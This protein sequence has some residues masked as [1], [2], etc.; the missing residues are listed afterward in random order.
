MKKQIISVLIVILFVGLFVFLF[1]RPDM[2][3]DLGEFRD[4]LFASVKNAESLRDTLNDKTAKIAEGGLD[5][6]G[7]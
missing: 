6:A 2:K 4:S 1:T 5:W 3:S 7:D